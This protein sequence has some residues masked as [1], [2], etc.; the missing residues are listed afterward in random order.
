MYMYLLLT[1]SV[2]LLRDDARN[3]VP[4]LESKTWTPPPL[5]K[6]KFPQYDA[7]YF[8]VNWS[9]TSPLW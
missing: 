9:I 6:L 8:L 2:L 4:V 5:L 7:L 1:A 3:S